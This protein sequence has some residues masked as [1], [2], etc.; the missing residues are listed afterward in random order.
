MLITRVIGVSDRK[1]TANF[2]L[3]ERRGNLRIELTSQLINVDV[4]SAVKQRGIINE[5]R[6]NKAKEF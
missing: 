6:V 2:S 5:N 4:P 1:Y 3:N